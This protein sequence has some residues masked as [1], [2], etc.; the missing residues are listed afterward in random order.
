MIE[1]RR[2]FNEKIYL[3]EMW[4]VSVSHCEKSHVPNGDTIWKDLSSVNMTAHTYL[5]AFPDENLSAR[6]TE[7]PFSPKFA[8]LT[9]LNWVQACIT[10]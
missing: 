9:P 6:L 2:K 4:H 7:F 8:W 5:P 1:I 10:Q 3:L